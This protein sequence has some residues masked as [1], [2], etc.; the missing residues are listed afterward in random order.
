LHVLDVTL[1]AAA[2]IGG[3]LLAHHGHLALRRSLTAT[4]MACLQFAHIGRRRDK[5]TMIVRLLRRVIFDLPTWLLIA[6]ALVFFYVAARAP[7][8]AARPG[9]EPFF[10]SEG[11]SSWLAI[12]LRALA[13]FLGAYYF[14]IIAWQFRLAL[15][16]GQGELRNI[17]P[18]GCQEPEHSDRSTPCQAWEEFC[19][20]SRSWKSK[21]LIVVSWAAYIGLAMLLF[22]T[23]NPPA[24]TVR[25]IISPIWDKRVLMLA[26]FSMHL[27]IFFAVAHNL[28][29]AF[30]VRK[31]AQWLRSPDIPETHR[32]P[33]HTALMRAIAHVTNAMTR[34]IYYPF[35]LLFLIIA[36]RQSFFDNFDW[37]M[38]LV[39]ISRSASERCTSTFLIRRSADYARQAATT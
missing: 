37:P 33:L 21:A 5:W 14:W 24:N 8:I 35:I 16:S 20:R 18:E 17:A 29:C 25:G 22:R 32:Q 26:V 7:G 12:W 19:Q 38:A 36:A 30:F 11:I 23:V 27:L 4:H 10:L 3:S 28:S 13:V 2:V 15:A 1:L 34:M 6:G 9:E 39:M 31:V